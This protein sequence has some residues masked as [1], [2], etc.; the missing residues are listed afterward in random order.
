MT[1]SIHR[2][3]PLAWVAGATVAQNFIAG[4]RSRGSARGVGGL[5]LA[6]SLALIGWAVAT[7]RR[8]NTTVD[9]LEPE[10]ASQLVT[11]GPFRL[12]RNP[13][14]VAMAG[15]LVANAAS[16]RSLVALMPAAGLVAL[17]DAT[18]I[19][20]EERAM[21][22]RFGTDW[23]DYAAVTPRWVDRRSLRR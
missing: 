12:S 19:E 3:P 15:V 17:M 2:V 21:R 23:D 6:G 13:M 20:V 16:R 11:D 18:Q 7:F 14:Y 1:I 5:A 9:P 8:H 22:A 10:R 4:P